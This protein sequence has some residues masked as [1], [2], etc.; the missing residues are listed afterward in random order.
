MR[1][2]F[3]K[4][5][6][7]ILLAAIII[8]IAIIAFVYC[9][10]EKIEQ[11]TEVSS[12]TST[13]AETETAPAP[14]QTAYKEIEDPI[15]DYKYDFN[16][17]LN[18]KKM[19]MDGILNFTY[20][21][22]NEKEIDELVFYLYAN[23]YSKE[24]YYAIEKELYKWGYANGFSSG[25]IEIN[26][27]ESERELQYEIAGSQ[28]HLLII[29][30]D[31]PVAP[32]DSMEL[33]IEY[34]VKIPN[35]FGR[36][37]YGEQ[38]ISLVNCNP[39]MAVYD[40]DNGYFLYE[41]NNIGD[42]FFTECADYTAKITVP[43]NYKIAPTGTI[44]D[45]EYVGSAAIYTVDGEN[46]RDFGFVASDEFEILTEEVNGVQVNA[47]GIYNSEINEIALRTAVDSIKVYS[48][49]FGDYPYKTFNVVQTNFFIGGM[50]YPGMVMIGD[51]FY[52]ESLKGIMEMII[53]HETAHQWW[54]SMVG[55]D[56]IAEPWLDEA[57]ATFSQR[58]YY[59]HVYSDNYEK[60]IDKY[61]DEDFRNREKKAEKRTTRIDL[62][63]MEYTSD[64]SLIV[65]GYGGWMM[66]DLREYLGEEDFYKAM[67]L[68]L[69]NNKFQIADRADLEEAIEQVTGE[70]ITWW[71]D[72][73][74]QIQVGY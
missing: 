3:K 28:E 12:P 23:S 5:L 1:N 31:K 36:F 50:E 26:N 65:Y 37:G 14:E 47:Y 53:V 55:N 10:D 46:R 39:I 72:E 57:L 49:V 15:K 70:D 43:K 19:T 45:T 11:P 42:P 69:E 9:R 7:I 38:T 25:S 44:T 74:F 60:M 34:T 56:Q 6:V 64:Y 32:N 62:N 2:I 73:N 68:Y 67:R 20:Y 24:E 48:E 51:R 41:Y 27:V 29:N 21:N 13:N 58:V 8:L 22:N 61:V 40:E 71:F 66:D 18:V 16:L 59:E 33:K 30:L 52:T 17:S 35:S 54:Y 4:P 63:T